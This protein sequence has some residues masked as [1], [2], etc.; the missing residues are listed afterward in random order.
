M[1]GI[2]VSVIVVSRDRPK[3][4]LRCLTGLR[5]LFY[6]PF[7]VIVVADPSGITALQEAGVLRTV[8]HAVFDKH[9][10]SAARNIGLGL[11]SGEVIAFIDDD[12]VPEP[13][14]LTHLIAPFGDETVSAAGGFVRGRNGITFQSKA[15]RVN[16]LGVHDDIALTDTQPTVLAATP[17]N[18]IKT[19]GTNCAFRRDVLVSLGGFDPAFH[20]YLDETDLNL[21]LARIGAKTAIV[22][23]AEVHH[24]FASSAQRRRSRMPKTLFDVGASLVVFLRKHADTSDY[25]PA[26]ATMRAEQNARLI[27]HMIAGTCEPGDVT[28]VMKTLEAGFAAGAVRDFGQ[29]PVPAAEQ[30]VFTR[31][32]T[33]DRTAE[34]VSL[35]G[36]PW[37]QRRLRKTALRQVAL[38]NRVSLFCFSPTARYHRVSFEPE[39]YW[40]QT[41][42]LFGRSE[43]RAPLVQILGFSQRLRREKKRVQHVRNAEND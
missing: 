20:F 40:F 9:N 10:I 14:W 23:L 6:D 12:A 29:M 36:R 32:E 17:G 1:T 27:R 4:L 21:R 39:G 3:A 30:P 34:S 2:A 41:G 13:T 18:A 26:R 35:A 37:S 33:L 28:A 5:Q 25:D 43:R 8:K 19:E 16:R 42:G 31:F 22:P 7:E 11:A 38:G 24:G 15:R